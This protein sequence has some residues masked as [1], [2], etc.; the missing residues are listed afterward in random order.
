MSQK[1]SLP[2][3]PE[4]DVATGP[5]GVAANLYRMLQLTLDSYSALVGSCD[6][7]GCWQRT[8]TL[9][10]SRQELANAQVFNGEF[11]NKQIKAY[12]LTVWSF[13]IVWHNYLVIDF[14]CFLLHSY[15]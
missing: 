7:A 13:N 12:L 5:R 14:G 2:G 4:W 10:P 1:V 6:R 3:G 15:V 8:L 11:V 9:V